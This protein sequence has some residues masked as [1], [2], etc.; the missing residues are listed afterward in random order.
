MFASEPG[1][2]VLF[3]L[4]G[5]RDEFPGVRHGDG[6]GH[7]VFG[8]V[9]LATAGVEVIGIVLALR[10]EDERERGEGPV[11]SKVFLGPVA[12][13]MEQDGAELERRIVG[14]GEAPIGGDFPRGVREVA[15][16][17][18]EEVGDFHGAGSVGPQPAVVSPLLQ[19]HGRFR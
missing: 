14:D 4:F 13:G 8:G 11:V 18:A 10:A 7:V 5:K 6:A 15:L 9:A 19:A 16:D 3:Q 12:G 2:H 17:D 1:E